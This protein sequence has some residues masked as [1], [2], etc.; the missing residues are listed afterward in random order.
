MGGGVYC[1]DSLRGLTMGPPGRGEITRLL[2][3][4]GH[5]EQAALGEFV[6]L[7]Y[8]E[9]RRLA[10]RHMQGR[11]LE[12]SLQTTALVNEAYLRLADA[13][14]KCNDRI[15]FLA[16]CGQLMRHILVDYAR[17]RGAA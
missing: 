13:R 3:A 10:H 4:W 12:R 9:L 6:P 5:G 1:C 15:H 8:A 16:I 2:S 17:S 14:I 7:M 11:P